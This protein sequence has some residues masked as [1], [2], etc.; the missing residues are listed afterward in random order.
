MTYKA[1]EKELKRK[2]GALSSMECKRTLEYYREMRDDKLSQGASEEEILSEFGSPEACA[3]KIL[4][5]NMRGGGSQENRDRPKGKI[6]AAECVG[7]FF[8]TVIFIIPL[9]S[10]A[11]ALVVS[12]GAVCVSGAAIGVAGIVYAVA[13]PFLG[14][15]GNALIASVGLGIASS[16]VGAI[17]FVGF[18]YATKYTAI[19][20]WNA[21]KAIY[22]RR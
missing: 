8:A 16:G 21:I 17:L 4:A 10:V 18:Y 5:E 22:R 11:L 2:L 13:S 9:A 7:I 3:E 15:Q 19:G 14:A 12:C 6:S 20:S 1:W